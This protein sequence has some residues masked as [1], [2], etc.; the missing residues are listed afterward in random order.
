MSAVTDLPRALYRKYV[1]DGEYS[2]LFS[3]TALGMLRSVTFREYFAPVPI[4]HPCLLIWGTQDTL[5]KP[6]DDQRLC[7]WAMMKDVGSGEGVWV[8]GGGHALVID[9]VLT[10]FDLCTDYVCGPPDAS[11]S[12]SKLSTDRD[13]GA[14]KSVTL[15]ALCA[16]IR[17]VSSSTRRPI[18]RMNPSP[19]DDVTKIR[20]K[21]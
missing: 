3:G 18:R 2:F 12:S 11:P 14:N 4:S 16:I 13:C 17:R 15:A 5:H 6:W 10:L 19:L 1:A 21:L 7:E 8:E 20:C 9:S